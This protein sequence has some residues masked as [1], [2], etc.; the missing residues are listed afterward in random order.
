MHRLFT[1]FFLIGIL[2]ALGQLLTGDLEAPA[3][4]VAALWEAADLAVEVSLGLIGVLALWSGLFRLAEES[5]LADRLAGAVRP[6]LAR[7][8]PSLRRDP[9]AGAAVS[10]NLAANMLGLDNA[11]T[12]LG[13]KAMEALQAHNPEPRRATDSQIMFLVLNTS[14]VTLVPVTVLL[15]RAQQGAADPA[16]VYLPMLMATT[17]STFVGVALTA[18]VQ[19][20]PLRDPLLLTVAAAWLALLGLLALGIWLAPPALGSTLSGLIGNGILLAVIGAFFWA[21]WRARVDS[22]DCFVEGAKEGFHLAVKLIPYLVAML[23]AIAM[24]RASGALELFLDGIRHGAAALG[25]DTRF[26]DALPVAILKPLSGSGARAAMLDVMQSQG[27]DS[28]AGKMAAVMQGS[29]ETTFYVLAV[30]F[31]SVGIR[32]MRYALWCGLGADVAGLVAAIG[33]SYLFFG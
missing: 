8:M 15:Y 30:Y 4:V 11:A 23:A 32:D 1:G 19:R 21:A 13:L 12:P 14:S 29:T 6:L 5:R 26:V 22:Y 16:A 9:G 27:V 20:I 24:L 7:L 28:L 10:M 25:W 2:G 17:V 31:G 33:L 3:R 18:R